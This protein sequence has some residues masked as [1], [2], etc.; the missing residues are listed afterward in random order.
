MPHHAAIYPYFNRQAFADLPGSLPRKT[1]RGDCGPSRNRPPSLAALRT[2]NLT[3]NNPSGKHLRGFLPLRQAAAPKGRNPYD[4]P[5]TA[6]HR[7][8]PI[9]D[10][11]IPTDADRLKP[12]STVRSCPYPAIA[13]LSVV[14]SSSYIPLSSIIIDLPGYRSPFPEAVCRFPDAGRESGCTPSPDRSARGTSSSDGRV[15]QP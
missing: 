11:V 3:L 2:G 8:V 13:I 10:S 15:T 7:K 6:T 12:H 1:G 5:V 9:P 4:V 14:L